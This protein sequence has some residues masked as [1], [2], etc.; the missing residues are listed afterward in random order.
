MTNKS[1]RLLMLVAFL[2]AIGIIITQ[3]YWVKKAY[4]LEEKEFD[5][6]TIPLRCF[7]PLPIALFQRNGHLPSSDMGRTQIVRN[8][9]RPPLVFV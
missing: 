6:N 7:H 5:L 9:Y 4:Q 1:I 3:T 8:N 2:G